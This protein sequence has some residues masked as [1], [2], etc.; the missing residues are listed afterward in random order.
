MRG[1]QDF[2]AAGRIDVFRLFL[3]LA[4]SQVVDDLKYFGPTGERPVV[5]L[6]VF[7]DGHDEFEELAGDFPFLGGPA[8]FAPASAGTPPTIHAGATFRE[9]SRTTLGWIR[10]S[11]NWFW[12]GLRHARPIDRF[13]VCLDSDVNWQSIDR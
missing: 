8:H 3:D 9:P 1:F 11:F 4:V 7:I 2:G 13:W 12:I 10:P 5:G 6:L